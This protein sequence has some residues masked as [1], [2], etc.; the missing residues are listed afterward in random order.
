[1]I[2]LLRNDPKGQER[3]EALRSQFDDPAIRDANVQSIEGQRV[4]VG[5][6]QNACL[7]YPFLAAKRL[8]VVTGLVARLQ[9]DS[10]RPAR[11]SAARKR[12][13]KADSPGQEE[14]AFADILPQIPD[15][16]DLALV[17]PTAW[18]E[19]TPFLRQLARVSAEIVR[20]LRPNEL[21]G[22][23]QQRIKDKRGAIAPETAHRLADWIGSDLQALDQ[24]LEKL[25]V[26]AGG[27]PITWD[28]V[29]ALVAS[30]KE[31]NIFTLVDRAAE[32]NA[33]AALREMHRLLAEGS[34]VQIISMLSRQFRLMMLWKEQL[35]GGVRPV[36]IAQ[37]L[38]LRDFVAEKL[39]RQAGRY[40]ISQIEAIYGQIV[41]ID[42]AS[43]TSQGDTIAALETLIVELALKR[44]VFPVVH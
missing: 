2:Y 32:G 20:P 35:G 31:A 38:G 16:T 36:T 13:T 23:I 43:K 26:F 37:T 8:V 44:P 39:G 34:P 19:G 6:L 3:L 12:L 24:D 14:Q 1:L 10:K 27:N 11:A 18:R 25:V 33:R 9:A 15:H 40:S 7:S 28:M 29:E 42:L 17:E 5:N 41:Q 4:S 22:W 21:P 30:A